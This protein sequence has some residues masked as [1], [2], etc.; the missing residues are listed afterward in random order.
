ME[1]LLFK[2]CKEMTGLHPHTFL[3]DTR[4]PNACPRHIL[5][6]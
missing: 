3:Q 6:Y 4:S 1:T 5:I 2:K